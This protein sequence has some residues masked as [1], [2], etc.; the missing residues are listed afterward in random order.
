MTV[1]YGPEA[2]DFVCIP[3]HSVHRES[4][5]PG[6]EPASDLANQASGHVINAAGRRGGSARIATHG[7]PLGGG[8][9]ASAK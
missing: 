7:H 9:S 3:A 8:Q 2:D 1:A 5:G 6:P 4:V